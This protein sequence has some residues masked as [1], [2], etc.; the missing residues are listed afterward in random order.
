[1]T[2]VALRLSLHGGWGNGQKE[3]VSQ[4]GAKKSQKTAIYTSAVITTTIPIMSA[5][6][7]AARPPQPLAVGA[8]S[9]RHLGAPE[10]ATYIYD[11]GWRREGNGI[12]GRADYTGKRLGVWASGG[13]HSARLIK[14]NT[15]LLNYSER[16]G[17]PRC[18]VISSNVTHS[19][20]DRAHTPPTWLICH[21]GCLRTCRRCLSIVLML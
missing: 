16:D 3:V 6:V 19:R 4:G 21:V 12:I 5:M 15:R 8:G 10:W 7:Q 9:R 1:M 11:R 13:S 20:H 18:Q 2:L 14:A 17:K